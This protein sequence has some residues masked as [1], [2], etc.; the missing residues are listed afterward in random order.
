MDDDENESIGHDE[1]EGRSEH[2]GGSVPPSSS[3]TPTL[4]KSWSV[5]RSHVPTFSGGKLSL[6][7][8]TVRTSSTSK[9]VAND[10]EKDNAPEK[11]STEQHDAP[12]HHPFL[13][14]PIAGDLAIVDA[15][16]GTMM[17]SVR[18]GQAGQASVDNKTEENDDD[19]VDVD[20]ITSYAL[21]T[22]DE[23]LIT[24]SHNNILRQYSLDK[25]SP[26]T[27]S[28][29]SSSSSSSSPSV[30]SLTKNWGKS[31]HT[32]P[33][34][35]MQF[36]ISNVFV[37]TGS[38]DGTAGI[39]DVRGGYVTHLF[40]PYQSADGGGSG[41]LSVTAIEWMPS[42]HDLVIA[43]GRDDGSIAIHNLREEK[44]TNVILLH[45]HVSA[46]TTMQ[47]P[48]SPQT[49]TNTMAA[50][51]FLTA[52]R[53]E[54]IN[55]WKMEDH[56]KKKKS[57]KKQKIIRY[58]RVQT[59]PVYEAIEGM[60]LLPPT[61]SE[62]EGDE[63]LVATAGSKGRIRLWKSSMESP[64]LVLA[65]EQPVEEAF[66][67][68]RGGYR[69]L[70]LQS[71]NKR[72]VSKQKDLDCQLI[73]A[74]AEHN[75]SFLSLRRTPKVGT[76]STV[77]T[78]VGHNDEILDMKVIPNAQQQHNKNGLDSHRI[79]VATNSAQV[80]IFD[81][82]TFS[83]EVL[84]R[85]TATV[86]CVD[87]SPCGRYI[88]TCGKD[89]T[90]RLWHVDSLKMVAIA[91]GHAEAVGSTALSR[92]TA[93]YDVKGKAATNGGGSFA[94][95]VSVDRTIKRWNLPGSEIL[96]STAAMDGTENEI[97]LTSF[98][99]ARAHEKDIN[100]VSVAPNDSLIATGSQDRTVKLWKASDLT[101]QA[102]LTG[103]RR[104][105]WDCQFSTFDRVLATASGDQTV[106]LW[107]LSDFTCVRTFQGHVSS[108][109]RVRFLSL[110]MQL[111]SS[112][113]DGLLKLWT[114]RTNE[115]E[116][117]LDGH[118]AKAWALDLAANGKSMVSGGADSR[119]LVWTDTTRQEAE[120]QSA[121][122]E[123]G[124]VLDQK[125]ANH[126]RHKEYEQALDITLEL[127]K[128]FQAL[129]VFTAIIEADVAQGNN[130]VKP[131]MRLTKIWSKE[132]LYRVL[133]YCRE[134]NTRSRNCHVALLIVRAVVCSL[135]V[136]QLTEMEGVPE[137]MASI[138]PYAERHFE[139][140]D[141]LHESSF[142]MEYV[143]SSMGTSVKSSD[144]RK[145]VEKWEN[146]SRLV[147]PT[148]GAD[149]R[150]QV[151]GK[152][153]VGLREDVDDRQ[154]EEDVLTIGESSD[155]DDRSSSG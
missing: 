130:G 127:D 9:S 138:V 5:T 48:L 75:I 16:R 39:Y 124:L 40:R 117:T 30:V 41:R 76:L 115:C 112:G 33:V 105:V 90:M 86:L 66:G 131:L 4:S 68:D 114:I 154:D 8:C 100:V 82:A 147:L 92:Q 116:A 143:L 15:E 103:H 126:L 153:V 85:H 47:W 122:K 91:T 2:D 81:V 106:K 93:R 65:E 59:L 125:L 96:N 142:L 145:D 80:R 72:C 120:A 27:D 128:P 53:D 60:I 67:Q 118:V 32:L 104:G 135:P 71:F 46:V 87:V 7:Y 113:A 45:D 74:D 37:A 98:V 1:D 111:M 107:S 42:I 97:S 73:V 61:T 57:S 34:N 11:T 14:L 137:I 63:I 13:I 18:G 49:T 119:I 29:S 108:V 24:C 26:S 84:D 146:E 36:H 10:S 140:L 43:I 12:R 88:A 148:K 89:R 152:A 133:K 79:V 50:K 58:N 51:L 64:K 149:G 70:L 21:S 136:H 110:G 20:A 35:Y 101:L 22:N 123:Q 52:G 19:Q 31:A 3:T 129:R 155:D 38:V 121:K 134:W 55:V 17:C 28:S 44:N 139:R 83:C 109:L 144:F 141:R 77:R 56:I 150:V 99:S 62:N 78:I 95:T 23:I 132:K 94:I 69:N 102:T 25:I 54:V 6:G 151:G